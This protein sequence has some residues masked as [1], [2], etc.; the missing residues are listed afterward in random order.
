MVSKDLM[1]GA[2][3]FQDLPRIP[4]FPLC[5]SWWAFDHFGYTVTD[6]LE[7]PEKG[8][9]A[10]LKTTA[11]LNFDAIE[12]FWDWYAILGPLGCKMQIEDKGGPMVLDRPP[13]KGPEDLKNMSM[14]DLTKDWRINSA[15]KSAALLK[16]RAGDYYL[17]GTFL[18]PFS[19]AGMLVGLENLLLETI[20][21]PEFVHD[22][23]A[24]S[25]EA[26]L[27]HAD[28]CA[29]HLDAI[30]Y[31]DPSA[32]GDLIS[33]ETTASFLIPCFRELNQETKNMG[34]DVLNHICGNTTGALDHIAGLDADAFSLDFKVD[35]VVAREKLSDRMALIGNIEPSLLLT[36][37]SSEIEALSREAV[38]K[39]RQ[40]GFVLSPGC[41]VP[42]ES[43]I[44]NVKRLIDVAGE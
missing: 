18:G 32:S 31:C 28:L 7:D 8:V 39:A 33:P 41:D 25:K 3:R 1:K 24:F 36:A 37:E 15:L 2:L 19:L 30:M 14:P 5:I 29:P 27:Q 13:I 6:V 35:L 26:L 17:F 38:T 40:K 34:I 11:M 21:R 9:D 22:L 23:M 42:L 16:E 20:E 43:P 44:E 4:V 10:Q 12:S